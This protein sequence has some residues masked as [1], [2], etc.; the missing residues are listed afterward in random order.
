MQSSVSFLRQAKSISSKNSRVRDENSPL[1]F[2]S[3][4]ALV[5]PVEQR[6]KFHKTILNS[7]TGQ[8]K[9]MSWFTQKNTS[10]QLRRHEGTRNSP[11]CGEL[12]ES[13]GG[14]R[15]ALHSEVGQL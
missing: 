7:G 13:K 1:L 6:P 11:T 9:A 3:D 14:T 8:T 12:L 10:Q 4:R 2:G 15:F 5:R